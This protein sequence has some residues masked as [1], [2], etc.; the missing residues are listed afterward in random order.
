M[1]KQK[2]IE[3]ICMY[4]NHF[5]IRIGNP[6]KNINCS[7]CRHWKKWFADGSTPKWKRTCA[8]WNGNPEV[9]IEKE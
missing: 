4:C 6:E 7:Y 9:K 3:K 5:E 1:R 8:N 2:Q